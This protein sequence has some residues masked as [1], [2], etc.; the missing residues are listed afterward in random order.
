M[1]GGRGECFR[2]YVVSSRRHSRLQHQHQLS[3]RPEFRLR[4]AC[5]VRW[6]GVSRQGEVTVRS[7]TSLTNS[8][9]RMSHSHAGRV[10]YERPATVHGAR[11]SPH[12]DAVAPMKNTVAPAVMFHLLDKVRHL[13]QCAWC[14]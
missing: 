1:R 3:P 13:P 10:Y 14:S 5:A 8:T 7:L 6:G 4:S 9:P 11:P 12:S 2:N